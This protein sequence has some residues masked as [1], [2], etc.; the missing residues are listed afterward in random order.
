L[1]FYL[2]KFVGY[3]LYVWKEVLPLK[4]LSLR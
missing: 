2:M 1:T 4:F 3:G